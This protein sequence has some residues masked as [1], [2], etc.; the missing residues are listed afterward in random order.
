MKLYIKA[1]SLKIL[2]NLDTLLPHAQAKTKML[3]DSHTSHEYITNLTTSQELDKHKKRLF[4]EDKSLAKLIKGIY[5]GNSS[6]EHLLP[7]IADIVE[8]RKICEANHY[9]FIFV[10]PPLGEAMASDAEFI[11]KTLARNPHSQV[12]ANDIGTLQQILQYPDFK[13]ILGLNFTK[14]IKNAFIDSVT[15]TEISHQQLQNQKELLSHCEFEVPESRA[16][17]KSIGV[18]R[19]AVENIGLDMAF[20]EDTPTMFCDIYYPHITVANSKACDIA[21]CF[22]DERGYFAFDDCPRYCNY[23][24]LIFTDTQTLDLRQRY[25][26]IYKTN[27]QLNIP[28][29]VYKNDKNRLIWEVFV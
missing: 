15:P 24:S 9:N 29:I 22:E 5:F 8:A 6:C 28:K 17:Y 26:S 3:I 11:L 1:N 25:N 23:A 19:F 13:P 10:F 18:S 21:G 12:V 20:L 14:V 2:K 16:F 7:S 27:T 4:Y